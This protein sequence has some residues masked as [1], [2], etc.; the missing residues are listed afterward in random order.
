MRLSFRTP[1]A[2]DAIP[3]YSIP[4]IG[5][6]LQID[7]ALFDIAF[8]VFDEIRVAGVVSKVDRIASAAPRCVIAN[9]DRIDQQNRILAAKLCNASGRVSAEPSPT[10]HNPISVD[11]PRQRSSKIYIS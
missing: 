9:F 3:F 8:F 5:Y 7:V 6:A 4:Q 2:F 1:I 11:P 10:H